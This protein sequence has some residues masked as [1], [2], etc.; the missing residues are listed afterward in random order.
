MITVYILVHEGLSNV[1]KLR[2][3]F[4]DDMFRVI[5]DKPCLQTYE[6]RVIKCLKSCKTEN[7]I[8]LSD[9][10]ICNRSSKH[11]R[12]TVNKIL[13]VEDLDIA[14]LFKYNDKCQMHVSVCDK[15]SLVRTQS[16]HGIEGLL[17]TKRGIDKVLGR[18]TLKNS[19]KF[20][21]K[22]LDKN[23]NKAIFSDLMCAVAVTPNIFE[24]DIYNHTTK[25][26]HYKYRNECAPLQDFPE[27]LTDNSRTLMVLIF[28]LII[29]IVLV[30]ALL[31][32]NR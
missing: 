30:W 24:Y 23:L 28:I 22:D 6:E 3:C 5:Y 20:K 4:E 8:V 19:K 1:T 12:K 21:T 15:Q 31:S 18:K 25:N 16:P 26:E 17:F 13:E 32:I 29:I 27:E 7:V 10:M 9:K 11:I 2:R 14:Y